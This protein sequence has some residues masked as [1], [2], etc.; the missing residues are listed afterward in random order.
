[1]DENYFLY[2]THFE[3]IISSD[4]FSPATISEELG[5][6]PSRSFKKG[7]ETISK[8]SGSIITKP[9]N[10]WAFS[11]NPT[12]LREE[13]ISHHVNRL[14]SIFSVKIDA[15]RKYKESPS[16]EV[17]LWVWIETDNAGIGLDLDGTEL[18][19]INCITNKVHISFI[20]NKEMNV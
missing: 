4:E 15:L 10:L 3:L 6:N 1:M 9:Y 8:K 17:S 20:S 11:S 16:C 18:D 7:D 2:R 12:D 19:F 13:T 5:V 14:K